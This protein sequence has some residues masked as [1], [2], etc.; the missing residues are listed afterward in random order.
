M[1]THRHGYELN[2]ELLLLNLKTRLRNIF[3]QKYKQKYK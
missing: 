1:S 3:I 2:E